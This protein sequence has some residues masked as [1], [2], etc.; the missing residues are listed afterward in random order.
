MCYRL[1]SFA[2]E[3]RATV[4]WTIGADTHIRIQ[5]KF[6]RVHDDSGNNLKRSRMAATNNL[7]KWRHGSDATL[8]RL[9]ESGK[10]SVGDIAEKMG[11]T[12]PTIYAHMR[13]IGLPLV[14]EPGSKLR[15]Y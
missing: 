5:H 8:T 14:G 7:P 11:V 9:C 2:T 6:L 10:C 3:P 12:Q 15:N 13:R 1:A 4:G